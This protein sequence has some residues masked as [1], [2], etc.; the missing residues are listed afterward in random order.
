MF[1]KFKKRAVEN[2]KGTIKEETSQCVDDLLPTLVGLASL[3]LFIFCN[4]STPKP[5][6]RSIVINNYYFG[7]R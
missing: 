2:I 4:L 3:G 1:E 6:T 7:R 5:I